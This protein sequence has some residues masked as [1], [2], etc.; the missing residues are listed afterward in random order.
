MADDPKQEEQKPDLSELTSLQFATAWTPSS[1]SAQRD[2]PPRRERGFDN[3]KPKFSQQKRDGENKKDRRNAGDGKKGKRIKHDKK[4]P[5][6]FS[7]EVLF[8]PDDAPIDKLAKVMKASMRTYQLF[9]IAQ[10]VLEKPERFVILAKNLPDKEGNTAPLYCAQPYNLPFEDEQSAKSAAVKFLVDE[11]FEKVQQE[12]EPPKGN[13]QI[14]NRSKITGDLLGAPNWHKYNE[15]L[16][17]YHRE[18][19]PQIPFEKFASEVE[20]VRD[21]DEIS[22]WVEQM[23]VRTVY[24]LKEPGEGEN[25]IFETREAAMNHVAHKW[26]AELVKKY[27]SK[28]DNVKANPDVGHLALSGI[29]PVENLK[30]LKGEIGSVHFKD[31]GAKSRR[32]VPYG[33]GNLGVDKMLAELDSQGYDGFLVIEYEADWDNNLPQIKKCVEYL[34]SH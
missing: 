11:K 14:V 22:K 12:C 9:D 13:F 20:G 5:F 29:D 19:C 17:E 6:N 32:C 28:Y 3:R 4:P 26:G 27:A 25:S 18:K 15:Y 23:K 21:A 10:L 30:I 34:R 2:F 1:N 8:Y 24:K 7:M 16:H 31:L 33:E